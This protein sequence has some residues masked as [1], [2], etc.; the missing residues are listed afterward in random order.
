MSRKRGAQLYE[1]RQCRAT[2]QS[3]VDVSAYRYYAPTLINHHYDRLDCFFSAVCDLYG[4]RHPVTMRLE[5][6]LAPRRAALALHYR[7][8]QEVPDGEEDRRAMVV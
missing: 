3:I 5:R 8:A 6:E 4:A 7:Q 1:C 2:T